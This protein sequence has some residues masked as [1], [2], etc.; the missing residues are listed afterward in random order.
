[1]TVGQTN[2]PQGCQATDRMHRALESG[3]ALSKEASVSVV[4]TKDWKCTEGL[5]ASVNLY[6]RERAL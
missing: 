6:R 1:M 5:C 3:Q 4:T 2:C